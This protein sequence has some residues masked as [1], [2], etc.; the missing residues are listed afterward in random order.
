[1][2]PPL[3]PFLFTLARPASTKRINMDGALQMII[4]SDFLCGGPCYMRYLYGRSFALGLCMHTS[5]MHAFGIDAG[6]GLLRYGQFSMPRKRV[7]R[8][9]PLGAFL[10]CYC[11]RR[12]LETKT[13]TSFVRT[14]KSQPLTTSLFCF[15][16][17]NLSKVTELLTSIELC[18]YCFFQG[19][20]KRHGS[21]MLSR[22]PTGLED[23]L[24]SCIIFDHKPHGCSNINQVKSDT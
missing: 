14:L 10:K 18:G 24:R 21:V 7:F 5:I 2:W 6:K 12:L 19:G 23:L 9:Q 4:N 20:I 17:N 8:A 3:W 22:M 16:M 11:K 13:N 1:M 15:V